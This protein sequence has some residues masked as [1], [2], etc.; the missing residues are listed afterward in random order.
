[1]IKWFRNLFIKQIDEYDKW[2]EAHP[3]F[4]LDYEEEDNG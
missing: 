3:D 1:M 4:F 2:M